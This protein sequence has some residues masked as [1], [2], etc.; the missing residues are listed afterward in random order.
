MDPDDRQIVSLDRLEVALGLGID[1][2]AERVGPARDRPIDGVVRRQLEEPA[3]RRT[4]LVQLAGRMEEARTVARGR[5]RAGRVAEE[6]ADPAERLV[7]GGGRGDERLDREIGVRAAPGKVSPQLAGQRSVAVAAE[8]ER[9][10][11]VK[12]EPLGRGD[13]GGRSGVR[14]PAG[15]HF[16]VAR[17]EIS[18]PLLGLLDV[19]LVEWIDPE[20]GAG[21]R[22]RHFPAEELAAK[23]DRVGDLD[24]DH[25]V[26]GSL[27]IAGQGIGCRD[28]IPCGA[29]EAEP[30]ERPVGPEGRDGSGRFAVDRDDPDA[31][32]AG[33]LGDELLRPGAERLDLGVG[34]ERDLVAARLGQGAEGEPEAGAG[35]Q[36]RIWLPAGAVHR[37]RRRK[38]RVE[39]DP[40]QTRRHEPHIRERGVAAADVGRVEEHCPKAVV[41]GDRLEALAG[42]GDRD[43]ELPGVLVARR[44]ARPE[45]VLDPVPG[46]GLE[47]ERLGRR[48]GLAR[49]DEQGG[50]WVEIVD[51]C[52]DGRGVGRVED[53]QI[54]PTLA[55]P[56]R[57]DEDFRSEA[58]AAHPGDD[59]RRE[60]AVTD[61]FAEPFEGG[62]LRREVV[63]RV[64]PA[65]PLGDPRLDPGIGRP[66]G[67]VVGVK[68]FDPGFG[69]CPLRR[70]L[71]R[72][73]ALAKAQVGQGGRGCGRLIGHR[74]PW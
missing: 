45:G 58:A 70:R 60:P 74:D 51:D 53:P 62:D 55:R 19:R 72:S 32:L 26:A 1:Q 10:V 66:E 42:V 47:G 5:R 6:Q 25:G 20:D 43:H 67:R 33:A 69:G 48:A 68:P 52:G 64:K 34:E 24:A 46:V 11:A 59:R 57:P 8:A 23:I 65:E 54:Q 36:G 31:A 29:G 12:G 3:G 37:G 9:C 40:D 13:R 18:R 35:I 21:D 44:P 50:E 4:A 14:R 17:Q 22:R 49:N 56:E 30:D 7:A 73:E 27:E 63:R 71:V 41:V 39:V 61:A 16:A 2:L 15:R 28:G 38:E